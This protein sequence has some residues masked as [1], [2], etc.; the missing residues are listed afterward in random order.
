MRAWAGP[1]NSPWQT[2]RGKPVA[3]SALTQRGFSVR[4]VEPQSE[5]ENTNTLMERARALAAEDALVF[6]LA[7]SRSAAD[8]AKDDVLCPSLGDET[9]AGRAAEALINEL[10][11]SGALSWGYSR[12]EEEQIQKHLEDLG[13]L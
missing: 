2:L 10:D 12:E 7:G 5:D 8:I 1:Q 13:Y 11:Q 3:S 4:Q 6:V 9:D